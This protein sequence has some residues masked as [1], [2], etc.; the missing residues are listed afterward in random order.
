MAKTLSKHNEQQNQILK[1]YNQ[2]IVI[3]MWKEKLI[4]T[5]TNEVVATVGRQNIVNT[6]IDYHESTWKQDPTQ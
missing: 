3:E 1:L 2:A 5:R 4:N 6:I